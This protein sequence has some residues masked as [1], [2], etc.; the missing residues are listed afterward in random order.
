M[1]PFDCIVSGGGPAGLAAATLAAKHG[2]RTALIAPASAARSANRCTDAAIDPASC[3]SRCLARTSADRFRAAC[4]AHDHRRN[5]PHH[6][7]ANRDIRS[8]GVR[9]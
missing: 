5:R 8:G 2:L 4:A 3:Q 1:E 9:S 7:R 6:L